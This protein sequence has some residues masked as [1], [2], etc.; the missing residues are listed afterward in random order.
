MAKEGFKSPFGQ[1]LARLGQLLARLRQL[2]LVL[3]PET[4]IMWEYM[5]CIRMP[6]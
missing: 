1:V 6:C 5:T 4:M 2:P 3:E